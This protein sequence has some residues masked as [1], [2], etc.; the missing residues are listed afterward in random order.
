[1]PEPKFD[2][3]AAKR[4]V[5]GYIDHFCGRCIKIDFGRDEVSFDRDAGQGAAE[6]CLERAKQM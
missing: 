1:M 4:A 2:E 5:Q 6:A 3:E